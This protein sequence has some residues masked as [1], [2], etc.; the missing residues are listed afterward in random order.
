MTLSQ[1]SIFISYR[2]SDSIDVT[3]R[4][5]DRLVS[6]YDKT[7]IFKDV[8][9]I[10]FGSDFREHIHHRLDQCSV[11][12]AV[13]GPTW[14]EVSGNDD[15]RR[16]D[17]AGDWV[18]LEIETALAQKMAVIP[19][20]VNNAEMPSAPA[21]PESLQPLAYRHYAHA[22]PDPDF[23]Q[24]LNRLIRQLDELITDRISPQLG[25]IAAVKYKATEERLSA[26][27]DDYRA[28]SAQL[29]CTD[30]AA[31]RNQLK[32]QLDSIE[33]EMDSMQTTIE[34]LETRLKGLAC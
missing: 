1:D 16:I 14:L 4:I 22:R 19:L 15:V 21:L 13:I 2:R 28:L 31:T 20:L 6:H 18:R 30:N 17:S 3:G 26:L 11:L 10:P 29:S 5:Y 7:T 34:A 27:T 8:D 33:A 32:R 23:H 12:I 9:S 24:D 25:R